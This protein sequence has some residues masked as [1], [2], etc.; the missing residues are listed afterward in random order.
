LPRGRIARGRFVVSL[1]IMLGLGYV[2]VQGI[3]A[4][5]GQAA[6]TV[7]VVLLVWLAIAVSVRRLHD[8]GRSAW[9]LLVFAVP[10]LGALWLAWVLLLQRGTDGD[11]AFGPDPTRRAADYL[12]VS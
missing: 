3:D 4:T 7:V 8:T 2:L 10:V 9:W 12:T 6:G 1:A 11:N 5:L